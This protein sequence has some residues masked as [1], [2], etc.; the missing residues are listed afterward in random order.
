MDAVVTTNGTSTAE[1]ASQTGRT[2]IT[3]REAAAEQRATRWFRLMVGHSVMLCLALGVIIYLASLPRLIPHVVEISPEGSTLYV[4]PPKAVTLTDLQI[5]TQLWEGWIWQ[6]R[7][8]GD[9]A[10]LMGEM[11]S[12]AE[13]MTVGEALRQLQ[14]YHADTNPLLHPE[15][16]Q[17][18]IRT[19]LSDF[20]AFKR[21]ATEWDVE[22][23]EVCT[24]KYGTAKKAMRV[25]GR[26][27]LERRLRPGPF[28]LM[29]MNTWD[30]QRSPLGLYVVAYSVDE[31]WEDGQ[32]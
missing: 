25:S 17:N 2:V 26:F 30:V 22:W 9:D 12:K 21:G 8:R 19:Q 24:P 4:G 11:R 7:R 5:A 15:L 23:R 27:T 16:Q 18:P 29:Q 31:T 14:T 28:G 3:A 20:G 1:Q 6:S 13:L 32:R 10:T